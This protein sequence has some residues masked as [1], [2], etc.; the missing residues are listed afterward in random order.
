MLAVLAAN[1]ARGGG[2]PKGCTQGYTRSQI[3]WHRARAINWAEKVL[4]AMEEQDLLEPVSDTL[5]DDEKAMGRE[6]MKEVICLLRMPGSNKDKLAAARTILEWTRP[7]PAAKSDVK[8][9]A[10]E[11]FLGALLLKEKE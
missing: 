11:D 7:K 1:R 2:R 5:L 8:I 4:T 10:A 3:A 6:A 9:D